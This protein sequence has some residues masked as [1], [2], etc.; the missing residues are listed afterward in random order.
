MGLGDVPESFSS[1]RLQ[2]GWGA[3]L[4]KRQVA[5]ML[6]RSLSTSP[7]GDSPTQAGQGEDVPLQLLS[8]EETRG[9]CWFGEPGSKLAWTELWHRWDCTKGC[10]P[11]LK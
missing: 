7:A 10:S 1:K 6:Q 11:A 9:E 4:G 5:L 2:E 8:S 3:A